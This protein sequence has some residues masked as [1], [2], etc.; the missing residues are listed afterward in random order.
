MGYFEI[1]GGARL[2]GVVT[3]SGAKNA[4]LGVIPAAILAGEMC[5]IE[6][7]PCVSDV[8]IFGEILSELGAA[9][10]LAKNGVIFDS[11][12]QEGFACVTLCGNPTDLS[13]TEKA[14]QFIENNARAIAYA[15]KLEEQ[16]GQ[17]LTERA[18]LIDSVTNA[19]EIVG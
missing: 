10:N 8:Y 19:V 14:Q 11:K 18:A 16:I 15:T 2:E 17:A 5:V 1:K 12:D 13:Q 9:V 3:I 7:L 6:N 4:G